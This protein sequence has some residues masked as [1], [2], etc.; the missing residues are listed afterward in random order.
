MMSKFVRIKGLPGC[1]KTTY[2]MK[3]IDELLND[4]TAD[5]I[6]DF[7]VCTFRRKMA[8]ELRNK[9]KSEYGAS[10]K[11]LANIGTIH[12]LCRRIGD[13]PIESTAIPVMIINA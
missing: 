10:D 12:A 3:K 7:A 13:I 4:G 1:G 9:I 2:L 5:S 11:D 6:A 8:D